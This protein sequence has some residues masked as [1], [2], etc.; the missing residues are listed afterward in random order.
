MSL[1]IK[2]PTI[3]DE[4]IVDGDFKYKVY[5][6][7][8]EIYISVSLDN[9]DDAYPGLKKRCDKMD[10]NQERKFSYYYAP[11]AAD[12]IVETARQ[13]F[14]EGKLWGERVSADN[15][16]EYNS[17]I[18]DIC[19]SIADRIIDE[20]IKYLGLKPDRTVTHGEAVA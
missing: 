6:R 7:A 19:W 12:Y 10:E 13:R 4:F 15:V 16:D 14:T 5:N 9:W 3:D 1:C 11:D 18:G 8:W 17:A 2:L 20:L